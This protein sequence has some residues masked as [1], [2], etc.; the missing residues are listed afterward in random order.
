MWQALPMIQFSIQRTVT[1]AFQA[2][3]A[4]SFAFLCE[5]LEIY[6]QSGVPSAAANIT[7]QQ[8]VY[9]ELLEFVCMHKNM[10]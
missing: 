5:L 10:F 1:S 8:M 3:S 4:Q 6:Q 2:I 9:M 7:L